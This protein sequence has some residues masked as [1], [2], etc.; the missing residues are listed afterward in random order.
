[1]CGI[2]GVFSSSKTVKASSVAPALSVLRHRGPDDEGL[3]IHDTA[4]RETTLLGGDDTPPE[5]G[6]RHWRDAGDA[7]GHIILGHR[8]L[9]ILDLSPRGHQPMVSADGT[10]WIVFNGEIYNYVELRDELRALGHEFHTGSDTEV[11]LH[12]WQQWG[13]DCLGRFNGDWAFCILDTRE[14]M[15]T[16]F[17]ARDR[18]GIKPLF[19]ARTDDAFWFASEAKA[20]V[21][22]AVPFKPREHAVVRFLF[23]GELPPGN[24][25]DTFF[26]NIQQLPPGEAITVRPD[27]VERLLWYD[28]RAAAEKIAHPDGTAAVDQMARQVDSAVKLRLRADVPVGSCLS[29]GV[30][31]SSIVG[32]MRGLL[33][34]GGGGALHTFSAVYREQGNFNE[35]EWI[36]QVVAHSR[37]TAH[38]LYPDDVPLT[39]MFDRMVWHQ[40]EPFQTASIFA[41]WCVMRE[42]RKEGVTVLLDGQAADELFGGYQ[43]GSYQEQF[44]EWLQQRAWGRFLR[45]WVRRKFATRHSWFAVI[46]EL[47]QSLVSGATG[48]LWVK[49]ER[50]HLETLLRETALRQDVVDRWFSPPPPLD[51]AKLAEEET[52]ARQKLA[53]HR[54]KLAKWTKSLAAS[55][56]GQEG[57]RDETGKLERQIAAK[58]QHIESNMRKLEG[59]ADKRR[60]WLDQQAVKSGSLRGRLLALPADIERAWQRL[61][62]NPRHCLRDYLLGQTRNTSLPHLLR[63]EDRNSM[64][65]SVEA[66]VPFTDHQLVEW[67]F[68]HANEFK[69]H[70]GWTKWVL[71]EAM[72]G[73]APSSVLWRRDKT[74]FETPDITMTRRL[75]EHRA[76][77][78]AQSEF[79]RRYLDAERVTAMCRRLEDGTATRDDARLVWRWL[80]L[81]SWHAQF[82][83]AGAAIAADATESAAPPPVELAQTQLEE[84]PAVTTGD[85]VTAAA[86]PARKRICIIAFS[87]TAMDARVQRQARALSKTWEVTVAGFGRNPFTAQDDVRWHE[88]LLDDPGRL[89]PLRMQGVRLWLSR[90][91]PRLLETYQLEFAHFRHAW[92]LVHSANF[93][94]VYC[95]DVD[96]LMLGVAAR[97]DHPPTKIILDLHEYPTRE[98]DS[99]GGGESHEWLKVRK[100]LVTGIMKNFSPLA[101][102]TLTVTPTFV[103][104]FVEEFGMK[105]PVVICN[106]PDYVPLPPRTRPPDGK[107]RLIHHGACSSF[108]KLELMIQAMAW[109]DDRFTLDFMLVGT[110]RDYDA[111]LRREAAKLRP[112]R[113]N[114]LRPVPPDRIAATISH[115][116][117]GVFLLRPD[118]FNYEH[119]LPNKFFDF[120]A[121][122]LGVAIGPTPPMA[123]L[124]REHGIGWIA[125]DFE[126][127]TFAAMLGRLTA[128]EIAE[129]QA[130]SRRLSETLNA[131]TE[132][133][134]LVA[135]VDQVARGPEAARTPDAD[136]A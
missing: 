63:F 24:G 44:L 72:H 118:L 12:A 48:A 40:D 135:F 49:Q 15:P 67:A 104:L 111:F 107:V 30:D 91:F 101:D 9:S 94:V 121:A 105:A 110:E 46:R 38:Y 93:D 54:E 18:Y 88:L 66:R 16:I 14:A 33:D 55:R 73:R 10:C 34:A 5:L 100:P 86:T 32:T 82:T 45:E 133:A 64:A 103:P 80:V 52:A 123:R 97:R 108:R 125:D 39:E 120:I 81:D 20:L 85:G 68:S 128:E 47:C 1:M 70:Q 99:R 124:T 134:K 53:E 21:G 79:L 112:G 35:S 29:G 74:G 96:T 75:I 59:L 78:P 89:I 69:I 61:R 71:R 90:W 98:L 62:R 129:K 60:R 131:A 51:L 95:N 122:G 106:A 87:P 41:Q 83:K 43:P 77:H 26:E 17:L 50:F 84:A 22:H 115:Y 119:A 58:R 6:L 113:V 28:L 76:L 57:R 8:R 114:F 117:I 13:R 36:K 7:A 2:V 92:H 37:S 11:I 130:A 116:D 31:S 56:S 42:A 19:F 109:L 126:P 4:R 25:S 132:M 127:R 23:G 65:F 136:E 102:G 3:L 27:G